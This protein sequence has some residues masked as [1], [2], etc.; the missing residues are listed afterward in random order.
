MQS[1]GSSYWAIVDSIFLQR[2][3][4]IQKYEELLKY[5]Y[6]MAISL[7]DYDDD[8]ELKSKMKEIQNHI[9]KFVA[10]KN[11]DSLENEIAEVQKLKDEIY[12]L[13]NRKHQEEWKK[14]KYEVALEE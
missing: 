2:E 14:Q 12:L 3:N 9:Y 11:S 10:S 6:A 4:R 7:H 8:K 1:N 13:I 5:Q